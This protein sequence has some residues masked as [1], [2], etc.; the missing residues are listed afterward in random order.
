MPR[1]TRDADDS[2]VRV[3]L[4]LKRADRDL[5]QQAADLVADDVAS[6]V[7]RTAMLEARRLLAELGG[8]AQRRE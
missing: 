2:P 7:R 4:R 6:F 3:E 1:T 5:L 8:S